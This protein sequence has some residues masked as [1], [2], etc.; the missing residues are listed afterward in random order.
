MQDL[1]LKKFRQNSKSLQ[2]A[3][4]GEADDA[5]DIWLQNQEKSPFRGREGVFAVLTPQQTG[6]WYWLLTRGSTQPLGIGTGPNP[7]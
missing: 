5:A 4:L 3:P 7:R 1:L 6:R 2:G